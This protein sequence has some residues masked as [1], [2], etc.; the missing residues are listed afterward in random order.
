MLESRMEP[1]IKVK[2]SESARFARFEAR[3]VEKLSI[4]V[5]ECPSET[6]RSHRCEPIK[7]APPVTNI[8]IA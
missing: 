3:P 8:F 7:P 5:T 4:A 6:R 2:S 1:S